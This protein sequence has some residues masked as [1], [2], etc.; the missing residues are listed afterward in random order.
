MPR[1]YKHY[2]VVTPMD[3]HYAMSIL[4]KYIPWQIKDKERLEEL[5]KKDIE[6]YR[7]DLVE[8]IKT[9][10]SNHPEI[11]KK[12]KENLLNLKI[13]EGMDTEQVNILFE[14]FTVKKLHG[15]YDKHNANELWI[16]NG[17]S[18]PNVDWHLYFKDNKL[19]YIEAAWI[20]NPL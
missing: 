6:K 5:R 11:D 8:K 3:S 1:T 9:Y 10:L 15:I 12:I 19:I 18:P 4:T 13:A 20:N 17:Y 16:F 14:G 7:N 2:N